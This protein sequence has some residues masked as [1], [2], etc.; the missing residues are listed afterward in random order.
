MVK[1][2]S[3]SEQNSLDFQQN[4]DHAAVFILKINK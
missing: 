2:S 3:K 4:N 1:K